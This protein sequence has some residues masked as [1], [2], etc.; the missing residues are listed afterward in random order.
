MIAV[1][2]LNKSVGLK[3]IQRGGGNMGLIGV[4]RAGSFF[5]KDPEDDRRRVMAP[6]KSNLAEKPPSLRYKIVSSP[7]HNTARV[8]WMG[9]SEYDADGL[10]ADDT[11]PHERSQLDEAREFLR[12]ELEAGPMWAK[13]VYKDARDAGIAERTLRRAKDV[14]RVVSEKIGTEGWS[15]R[16]PEQDKPPHD[17]NEGGHVPDEGG[18]EGGHAY[19]DGHLG[20]LGHLGR[21]PLSKGNGARNTSDKPEGGQGGQGGQGWEGGQDREGDQGDQDDQHAHGGRDDHDH[22]H[23]PPDPPVWFNDP[24]DWFKAQAAKV[25]RD[26]SLEWHVTPLA[27]STSHAL[28]GT[29]KHHKEVRPF[30]REYLERLGAGG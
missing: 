15:W 16:L 1:R 27:K 14:L 20:H 21:L 24:P 9:V 12:A 30:V 4:A 25:K 28:H 17:S 29:V 19:T 10:A 6:H 8:E 3:A 7:V 22:D 5:A 11:T 13:Q 26:G 23:L 2:H 18:H